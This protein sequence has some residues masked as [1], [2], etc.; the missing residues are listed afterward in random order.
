MGNRLCLETG[1]EMWSGATY[2]KPPTD[3]WVSKGF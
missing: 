3:M 2:T 1:E